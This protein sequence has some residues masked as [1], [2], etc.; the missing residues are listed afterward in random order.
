MENIH[1]FM[2]GRTYY[3]IDCWKAW[4]T[5]YEE[6]DK[7]RLGRVKGAGVV[8]YMIEGDAEKAVIFGENPIREWTVVLG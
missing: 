4:H 2:K 3:E 6:L 5:H 7:I 1:L 8:L